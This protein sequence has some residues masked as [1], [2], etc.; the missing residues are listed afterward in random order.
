MIL[1]FLLNHLL[2][3]SG[4]FL[5][6]SLFSSCFDSTKKDSTTTVTPAAYTDI[7]INEIQSNATTGYLS[8]DFVELYNNSSQSY[9]FTKG[10]WYITDSTGSASALF[11]I[12]GDTVIAGKGYLVLLPDVTDL[13]TVTSPS[14]P[15]G[16]LACVADGTN[17]NFGLGKSDAVYLYYTGSKNSTPTVAVDSSV[18]TAHVA[19]RVRSPDGGSW[20]ST[21]AHTPTPGATNL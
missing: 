20:S 7:V 10:E 14:P 3:I 1:K 4:L 2:P 9:T 16:S 5:V 15:T 8:C 12:P 19:T 17:I 11:Y 21:D 6:V 13:T 18:W